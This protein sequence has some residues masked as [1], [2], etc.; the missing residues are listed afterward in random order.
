MKFYIFVSKICTTNRF[1]QNCEDFWKTAFFGVSIN[2]RLY[3]LNLP[4]WSRVVQNKQTLSRNT[5]RVIYAQRNQFINLINHH[6]RFTAVS[7]WTWVCQHPSVPFLH[8]WNTTY[9]P[10]FTGQMSL[11]VRYHDIITAATLVTTNIGIPVKDETRGTDLSHM[12]TTAKITRE[13]SNS[14][15]SQMVRNMAHTIN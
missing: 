9:V 5:L 14:D 10:V 6:L 1:A 13:R 11:C 7:R 2:G 4:M 3:V 15:Q 12:T 8:L